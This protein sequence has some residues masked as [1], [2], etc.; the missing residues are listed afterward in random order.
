MKTGNL[1]LTVTLMLLPAALSANEDCSPQTGKAKNPIEFVSQIH[2]VSIDGDTVTI[3][4]YR[5]PFDIFAKKWMRVRAFDGRLMYAEDLQ[6]GDNVA[7]SGDL[8][9]FH[10]IVYAVRVVLQMRAEHRP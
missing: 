4:L 8:D 3:H 1:L 9:P 6:A 5:E 7:I 2:D 10:P